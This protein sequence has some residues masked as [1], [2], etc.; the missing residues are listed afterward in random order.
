MIISEIL[1]GLRI[2]HCIVPERFRITVVGGATLAY[3]LLLKI[4]A[5]LA[6]SGGITVLSY[7]FTPAVSILFGTLLSLTVKRW[8]G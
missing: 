5:P 3:P 8:P 7:S 6:A 1:T 2:S 4:L